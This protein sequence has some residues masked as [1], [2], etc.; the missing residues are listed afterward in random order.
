MYEAEMAVWNFNYTVQNTPQ[1]MFYSTRPTCCLSST[2]S[3]H[4]DLLIPSPI[5]SL[6]CHIRNTILSTTFIYPHLVLIRRGQTSYTMFL[7]M[8]RVLN[9]YNWIRNSKCNITAIYHSFKAIMNS[10]SIFRAKYLSL[11]E[12]ET[13]FIFNT[14][15]FIILRL[16]KW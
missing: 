15:G 16:G 5:L 7:L 11:T 14:L 3:L 1:L 4:I 9:W 12:A 6:N 2:L 8:N 13:I 10:S